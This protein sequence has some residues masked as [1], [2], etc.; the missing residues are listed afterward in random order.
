ME[1]SLKSIFQRGRAQSVALEEEKVK[2]AGYGVSCGIGIRVIKGTEVGYAPIPMTYLRPR[3]TRL[4]KSQEQ[5]RSPA[6]QLE[7]LRLPVN[8]PQTATRFT[9]IPARSTSR[10]KSRCSNWATALPLLRHA[11]FTGH[12]FFRRC[13][14]RSPY[15]QLRGSLG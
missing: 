3:C 9:L 5:L 14:K 11:H 15:R 6:R 7:V 8:R 2:T 1:I 4:L 12:G 13:Y 10:R